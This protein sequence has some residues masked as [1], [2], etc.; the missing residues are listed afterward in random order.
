MSSVTLRKLFRAM[1]AGCEAL[2]RQN[3]GLEGSCR[4]EEGRDGRA[5]EGQVNIPILLLSVWNVTGRLG[6]SRAVNFEAE[7]DDSV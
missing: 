3:G 6:V 1:R 5:E 7:T 2:S 4:R